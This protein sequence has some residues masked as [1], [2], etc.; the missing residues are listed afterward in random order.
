IAGQAARSVPAWAS[1]HPDPA[2][3]VRRALDQA[4][5]MNVTNGRTNRDAFM[6]AVNNVLYSDDPAQGVTEGRNFLH[7]DMRLAFTVPQGFGMANGTAAVAISGTGGQGQFATAAFSGDLDAYVRAAYQ[8]VIGTGQNSTTGTT[9]TTAAAPTLSAIRRT[10]VNGL[11]AATATARAT[12]QSGEVELTIFAY[13]FAADRAFH[14]ATV[15]PVATSTVFEPMFA[16]VRRMTDAEARAIR[17]RRIN[18]VTVQRGDTQQSMANRMA[19]T[20][21][22]L[23]RFAVLNGLAS[24]AALTPGQKVKIVVYGTR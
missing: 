12:T 24:G 18:V 1:T 14:F 20:D 2:S 11:P 15:A 4:R 9:G 23:Q 8:S 5:T 13:Q 19:Y 16:S 10:T 6:A 21:Y 3:R 22:Q 17:P 7:P